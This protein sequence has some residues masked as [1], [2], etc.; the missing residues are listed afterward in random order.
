M[1][2]G[3]II[4]SNAERTDGMYYFLNDYSEGALPPVM[5]ALA[6]TN[7]CATDGYGMDPYCREAAEK[8]TRRQAKLRAGLN[9]CSRMWPA[10]GG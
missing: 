5:D 8:G 3:C 2:R 7:A 10:R 4:T 1:Q 6:R 9:T